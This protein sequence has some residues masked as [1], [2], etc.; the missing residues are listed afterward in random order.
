MVSCSHDTS[1]PFLAAT[2]AAQLSQS[3]AENTGVV[4]TFTPL[5]GVFTAPPL[6]AQPIWRLLNARPRLDAAPEDLRGVPTWSKGHYLD[7]VKAAYGRF[8]LL[9]CRPIMSAGVSKDSVVRVAEAMASHADFHTGRG[10]RPSVRRL[11]RM[12]HCSRRVVQRARRV[13]EILG[14]ARL[15]VK[16]RKRSLMES[17]A[18]WA[19]GESSRG[20][21]AEYALTIPAEIMRLTCDAVDNDAPPR[22]GHDRRECKAL[23]VTHKRVGKKKF[24]EGMRLATQW[25]GLD[26]CPRWV[27]EQPWK[28][29]RALQTAASKGWE[30]ADLDLALRMKESDSGLEAKPDNP[31]GYVTWL[32]RSFDTPPAQQRRLEQRR[33]RQRVLEENRRLDQEVARRRAR[34]APRS[35]AVAAMAEIRRR[36]KA[37]RTPEVSRPPVVAG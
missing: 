5:R 31:G 6:V 8:Y 17:L 10:C 28:V 7:A 12:T 9:K 13:L 32:V 27:R 36:A 4:D 25:A 26:S 14:L 11:M 22:R 18:S 30:P 3:T 15:V 34:K 29:A 33:D 20:W 37:R 24:T 2:L 16:G 19:C 35:V 23:S 21:A 1:Y